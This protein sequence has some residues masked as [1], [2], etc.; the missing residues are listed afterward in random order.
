MRQI[1]DTMTSYISKI[2][3]LLWLPVFI[4][5]CEGGK[6]NEYY[7][8]TLDYVYCGQTV[9]NLVADYELHLLFP[10]LLRIYKCF[11]VVKL[12]ASVRA[13]DYRQNIDMRISLE[14]IEDCSADVEVYSGH[15]SSN[16]P[17]TILSCADKPVW[18][19]R[20]PSNQLFLKFI[21]APGKENITF[22][23]DKMRVV[24]KYSLCGNCY[25]SKWGQLQTKYREVDF[26]DYCNEIQCLD[27]SYV[28]YSNLRCSLCRTVELDVIESVQVCIQ[29]TNPANKETSCNVMVEI[30]GESALTIGIYLWHEYCLPWN[31]KGKKVKVISK[32][33]KGNC[34]GYQDFCYVSVLT[35]ATK[36]ISGQCNHWIRP[37]TTPI[38]TTGKPTTHQS[39]WSNWSTHS[40]ADDSVGFNPTTLLIVGLVIATVIGL[41]V[42][43]CKKLSESERDEPM[44]DVRSCDAPEPSA[45]FLPT[46]DP[47]PSE[48]ENRDNRHDNPNGDMVPPSYNHVVSETPHDDSSYRVNQNTDHDRNTVTA[49]QLEVPGTSFTQNPEV[50]PPSY[51]DACKHFL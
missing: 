35:N 13:S 31:L 10:A 25:M 8:K 11:F 22:S 23:T 17:L 44:D 3:W 12:E 14:R 7:A 15:P 5:L 9:Y 50:P 51:E 33:F 4:H 26:A 30:D 41:T 39:S 42:I 43:F 21:P 38:Y 2:R 34:A 20:L 37:S 29:T 1:D 16:R 40:E 46:D 28:R 45:P 6:Y 32:N 36:E 24:I 18:Q 49:S 47:D 27:N 19:N 48:T